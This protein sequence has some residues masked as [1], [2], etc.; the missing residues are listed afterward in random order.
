MPI[1]NPTPLLLSGRA[2]VSKS[3]LARRRLS[4]C[5][6]TSQA[7]SVYRK[8]RFA[9]CA[10]RW[11]EPS[12][13]RRLCATRRLLPVLHVRPGVL[14]SLGAMLHQLLTGDDPAQTPFRFVS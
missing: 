6:W 13:Q 3:G 8:L 12:V 1:W 10:H 11:E 7:S 4:I 9:S 5:A 14:Y 2:I